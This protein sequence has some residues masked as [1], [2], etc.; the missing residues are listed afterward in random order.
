MIRI[1]TPLTSIDQIPF[2]D[3]NTYFKWATPDTL[4]LYVNGTKMQSWTH[5]IVV[6]AGNP[7]GMLLSLTYA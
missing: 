4:E 5:T 1:E 6:G 2:S 3:A 7:I